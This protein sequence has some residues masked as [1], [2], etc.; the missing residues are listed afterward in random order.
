MITELTLSKSQ[1]VK[2]LQCPKKLW[3]YR[4]RKDLMPEIDPA[5]QALFDAG[6]EIGILA[7]QYYD[8]GLEVTEKYWEIEKAAHS[9]QQFIADGHEI[10]YEATAIHPVDGSYSRIDIFHKVPGTDEWDLIEV[11]S[12]T[13][14]KD[15]HIDDMSFQYYVFCNAGH[16]IRRCFMMLIN[17]KYIRQGDIDPQGLFHLEDISEE[18][19]AKQGEVGHM[20][21]QLGHV[22]DRKEEPLAEIGSRCFNPFECDYRHH[23]WQHVPDYSIYNVFQNKKA[24]EIYALINSY[25]VKDI[26]SELVP[27]GAKSVDVDCHQNDKEYIEQD[28]TEQFLSSLE[29]PLYYL[30]YETLMSGVP[31]YDGTRPYQ[32]IPFQFSLYVQESPEAEMQHFEFLH[33]EPTDP[34]Q[35]FAEKL[36]ELCGDSGSVVVYNAGFETRINREVANDFP[37]YAVKLEGINSRVIDLM[38]PFQKRWLYKPEQMGSYSIKYVL[39][40]YVPELSY[41]GMAIA[42]GGDAM[43]NYLR[44]VKGDIPANE[45][46][47][48]WAALSEYCKLDTLA[49]VKI[50]DQLKKSI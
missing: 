3:Y 30:D 25:D 38:K 21:E 42:D 33:K 26:P 27:G 16:K 11:K 23:C 1:Y 50:H 46:G 7:Q 22:L 39:P 18:V 49:M 34:R 9:T 48:L 32:Q 24:D 13:G 31:L 2:G 14:V 47:A 43:D 35:H 6:N 8:G 28:S 44:F 41:D 40:A 15:Y 19:F 10:I 20:A 17:N 29:Y 12:S 37:Q 45:H 4:H 5:T 36:V